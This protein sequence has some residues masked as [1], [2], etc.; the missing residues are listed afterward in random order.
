MRF[1]MDELVKIAWRTG[2]TSQ[3]PEEG[4]GAGV[5]INDAAVFGR[6][7]HL[8]VTRERNRGGLSPI[9]APAA[10]DHQNPN[11]LVMGIAHRDSVHVSRPGEAANR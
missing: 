6:P 3:E 10:S 8:G 4:P 5:G 7:C 9:A 1:R 2:M 11:E